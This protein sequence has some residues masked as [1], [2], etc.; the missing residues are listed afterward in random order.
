MTPEE[1]DFLS[2][3][4]AVKEAEKSGADVAYSNANPV[5]ATP[6]PDVAAP[7]NAQAGQYR[8]AA[9]SLDKQASTP[10]PHPQNL[11]E[12]VVAGIQS[13]MQDFGRLGAP[14][15]SEGQAQIARKNFDEENAQRVS[16]AKELR[17]QA[18]NQQELGQRTAYGQGQQDIAQAGQELDVKREGRLQQTA[19]DPVFRNQAP[20]AT[21]AA[22]D[23]HTGVEMPGTRHTNPKEATPKPWH[24]QEFNVNGKQEVWAVD[25]DSGLKDHKVGDAR[26]IAPAGGANGGMQIIQTT[27]QETGKPE[28]ARAKVAGPEGP[29]KFGGQSVE[30]ATAG[31]SGARAEVKATVDVADADK[32]L[33]IMQATF[34]RLKSGQSKAPGADDMVLLSNHIAMTMGSVKGARTGR[35]IIE[36]HKNAISA[37]QRLSRAVETVLN[38]GQ[39]TPGQRAEFVDLAQRNVAA[40]HQKQMDLQGAFGGSGTQPAPSG[41]FVK[42]GG[43]LEGLLKGK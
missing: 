35:D 41:G 30:N 28:Y 7:Y 12:R 33:N 22:Y 9:D 26:P 43:A 5:A 25:P 39:L 4:L 16:R 34:D 42:P 19:N 23:P 31:N 40:M 15:G 27:N 8:T 1:V 20:G 13:G 32:M 14:G 3:L 21:E 24:Y 36:A 6:K 37:D 10:Y 11:K 38:G 17:N 29:I 2:R 18:Q